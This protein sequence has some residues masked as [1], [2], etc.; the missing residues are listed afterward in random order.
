M[1]M[2]LEFLASSLRRPKDPEGFWPR[3][4]LHR[5]GLQ[6]PS[7]AKSY[8]WLCERLLEFG[9]FHRTSDPPH[10]MGTT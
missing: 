1:E 10:E 9:E 5:P 4:F 3:S 2:R 8:G 7:C 6:T